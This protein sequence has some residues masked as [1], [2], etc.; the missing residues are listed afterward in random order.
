MNSE[1]IETI[2]ETVENGVDQVGKLDDILYQVAFKGL[3]IIAVILFFVILTK[4]L[5]ALNHRVMRKQATKISETRSATIASIIDDILKYLISFIAFIALLPILGVD[6]SIILASSG[7]LAIVVGVGGSSFIGDFIDGFFALFEGYYDVG[8]YVKVGS[9][10]G[11]I[12]DIGLKTTVLK[13]FNN[14]IVSVPNSSVVEVINLS[15]LNHVQYPVLCIAYD[16]SIKEVEKIIKK[17]LLP[18]MFEKNIILD[19]CYL[20]VNALGESSVEL[21]F[22]MMS[23]EKNRFEAMRQF[24]REA[25]LMCDENDIEIPFNQLVVHSGK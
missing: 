20:G 1:Q 19:F 24:N 15:K 22:E 23:T 16:A 2:N 9:Y 18:V 12:I 21:K 11:E 4:L 13:T 10:E 8:D 25:K 5:M 14:E 17:R 7:F 6:S 3:E